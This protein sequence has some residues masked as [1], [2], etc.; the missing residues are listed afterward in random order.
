[1]TGYSNNVRSK[2]LRIA[3]LWRNIGVV[4]FTLV[5]A[6]ALATRG[7]AAE[8][9]SGGQ[10]PVE[11]NPLVW[12][13]LEQTIQAKPGQ[14]EATFVFSVRNESSQPVEIIELRPSCGCTVVE[15]PANPW[16]IEAGGK[17]EF[18][19]FVE[20]RGKHG[21]F[22]KGIYVLSSAGTQLLT[23]NV[24]IPEMGDAEREMNRQLAAADRQAVFRGKCAACHAEPA[25]GKIGGD[26]FAAACAVCHVSG[27]RAEMVPDL[28][29]V[30]EPRDAAYWRKWITEGKEGTLMPAF[31]HQ[32]GGPLTDAQVDSLVEYVLDAFPKQPPAPVR[33]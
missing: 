24:H 18:R 12:N 33:R 13:A 32:H 19:A 4:L 20:F 15:P 8:A 1:M 25:F 7:V 10:A 11:K 30:K 16:I 17:G 5:L 6:A 28:L 3:A 2:S 14:A 9:G 29:L 31:A 23:V 26:L 22:S 27:R 21:K